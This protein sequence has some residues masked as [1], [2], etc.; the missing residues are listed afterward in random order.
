MESKKEENPTM[1]IVAE[2]ISA[3]HEDI[4]DMRS[5]MKESMSKVADAVQM[6]VRLEVRQEQDRSNYERLTVHLDK[7]VEKSEKLESRIDALEK[8]QP[9]LSRMKEW[10]Y[11]GVLAI[12]A[13]VGAF[14]LKFVG[15]Y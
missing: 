13:L 12:V 8:E 11:K 15:L 1:L 2:R 5:D 9:D 4:T 7:A 14:V 6:L 10:F 3:L